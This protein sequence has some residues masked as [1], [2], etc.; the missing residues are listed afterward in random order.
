MFELRLKNSS[1]TPLNFIIHLVFF[2]ISYPFYYIFTDNTPVGDLMKRC[3]TWCGWTL[4]QLPLI[5]GTAFYAG[6]ASTHSILL[7]FSIV[8]AALSSL[9]EKPPIGLPSRPPSF[10]GIFGCDSHYPA[11]HPVGS[12][13]R[14]S[15]LVLSPGRS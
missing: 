14:P 9:V 1:T 5:I 11:I 13:D 10:A 6:F 7:A 4:L 15:M 8:L 2:P 3:E 12:H